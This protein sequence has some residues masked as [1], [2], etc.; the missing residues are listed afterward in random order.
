MLK[1]VELDLMLMAC[2]FRISHLPFKLIAEVFLLF[3][4]E[5]NLRPLFSKGKKK[6]LGRSYWDQSKQER[7]AVRLANKNDFPL[8]VTPASIPF[9]VEN[10]I[11]YFR[12]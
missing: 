5:L 2:L 9:L 10:T 3:L 6:L 4:I 7:K 11:N 8:F 1:C 12:S